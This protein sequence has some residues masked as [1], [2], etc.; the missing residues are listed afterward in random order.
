M[1][2]PKEVI[3]DLLPIYLAGEV[4]DVTRAWIQ[5]QLA[6][7]PALAEQARRMRTNILADDVPALPPELEMVTLQRTRRTLASMRWLFGLAIAC[8]ALA[9]SIRVTLRP[10]FAAR[11]LLLEYPGQLLPFAVVGAICWFFYIRL[12]RS[13]RRRSQPET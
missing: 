5:E 6:Q 13:L 8:T 9:F 11:P 7:D 4:S 10:E 3:L 12:K 2:I 1:S